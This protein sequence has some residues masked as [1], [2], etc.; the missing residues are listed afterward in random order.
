M[1]RKGE[2]EKYIRSLCI[3]ATFSSYQR[4]Q[5]RAKRQ[6][7][8]QHSPPMHSLLLLSVIP[9]GLHEAVR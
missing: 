6:S 8:M 7:S 9:R 2:K 1:E 3:L 5:G 4:P